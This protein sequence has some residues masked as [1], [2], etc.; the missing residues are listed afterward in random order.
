MANL[1]LRS[2]TSA[3]DPGSTSAKGS[4]LTHAEMDSN[5]ILLQTDINSKISGASPTLTGTVQIDNNGTLQFNEATANGSNYVQIKSLASIASNYTLT[6][7][8]ND[9]DSGQVLTTDGS[10]VLTWTSKTTSTPTQSQSGA[11]FTLASSSNLDLNNNEIIDSNGSSVGIKLGSNLNVNGQSILSAS[12]GN[13]TIEPN[14]TGVTNMKNVRLGDGDGGL[15]IDGS[16]FADVLQ[17]RRQTTSHYGYSLEVASDSTSTDI[18]AGQPGGAFGLTHYSDN[19]SNAGGNAYFIGSI[20][21]VVGDEGTLDG[22]AGENNNAIRMITYQD[23]SGF[24]LNTVA[25]FRYATSEFMKGNLKFDDTSGVITIE[26]PTTN[27][28]MT[29]KT[30]GTGEIRLNTDVVEHHN[31]KGIIIHDQNQ[32][33]FTDLT[34]AGGATHGAL[35]GSGIVVEDTGNAPNLTLFA[36][37]SNGATSFPNIWSHRSRDDGAGN[38]DFLDSGDVLFSFFGAAWDGTSGSANG[39]GAFRKTAAVELQASENHSGSAGGGKIVFTTT[40]NGTLSYT[41]TTRMTIDEDVEMHKNVV[42]HNQSGDPST[43]ANASHIYAK[44]DSSSSEV[45]VRDEAGNVTK[46]SPHN[47]QG[48]WEYYSRNINTGKVVRVNMEQMIRD[49]EQLTGKTYIENE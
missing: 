27:D 15:Y 14:G 18:A 16:S 13:I 39:E 26:T 22:S 47:T 49:I 21:G 36:H 33:G 24:A 17:T 5:F 45:Y 37:K 6:L 42:L 40:A 25:E 2:T 8:P 48:E 23:Q 31:A 41:G 10:G 3:T 11:N 43:V 38:K 35:Y 32:G 1:K 46:I 44:D 19:Y 9:G 20:N 7:P 4:A 12:N 28:H 29:L 30:N 34:G